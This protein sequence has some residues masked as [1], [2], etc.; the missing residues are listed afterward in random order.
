MS[1]P[2]TQRLVKYMLT[3]EISP[4]AEQQQKRFAEFMKL[5]QKEVDQ[6]IQNSADVRVEAE[7]SSADRITEMQRE[8]LTVLEDIQK[9]STTLV[10]M[11]QAEQTRIVEEANRA[12]EEAEKDSLR[13]IDEE[14]EKHVETVKRSS[15]ELTDGYLAAT[16]GFITLAQGAA[17]VGILAEEDAEKMLRFIVAIRGVADVAKGG[18]ELYRGISAAV[19]AYRAS[20]VAATAAE[21]ALAAA[22]SRTGAA[23]NLGLAG[24]A[25]SGA[26]SGAGGLTTAVSGLSLSVAALPAAIAAAIVGTVGA[27]AMITNIGGSR[28]YV[29]GMLP[30]GFGTPG[31][32]WFDW[33]VGNPTDFMSGFM[34]SGMDQSGMEDWINERRN[35]LESQQT[36][37]S[38]IASRQDRLSMQARHNAAA[39]SQFDL[40]LQMDQM[41]RQRELTVDDLFGGPTADTILSRL[42]LAQGRLGNANRVR[43]EADAMPADALTRQG[44]IARANEMQIRALEEVIALRKQAVM[45]QQQE[46]QQALALAKEETQEIE[47]QLELKKSEQQRIESQL[48]SARQRFG[49]LDE[50]TQQQAIAAF[51]KAQAGGTLN[52]EE[53]SLLRNVGTQQA[54]E[55]AQAADLARADSANF[56]QIFGAAE[57]ATVQQLLRDANKLKL[58]LKDKREVEVELKDDLERM[59]KLAN[60]MAEE[61]AS[62][63]NERDERLLQRFIAILEQ[64]LNNDNGNFGGGLRTGSS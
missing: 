20:V 27:G 60:R 17:S 54:T 21:T 4:D 7:K 14:Y 48:L 3:V 8:Q 25:A 58:E 32:S 62:Q 36:T 24:T 53:S 33:A 10:E 47:R 22:R 59:E 23:G 9:Q 64:K 50:A 30:E 45:L 38:R 63:I 51:R 37:D 61:T 35:A 5:T 16:E 11:Q 42:S 6:A 56:T 15:K 2:S 49:Q 41:R 31:N 12:R 44:D 46:G 19:E 18:V 26:V 34:P 29:A 28:D 55:F 52:R 39:Q 1:D 40:Q 57:N 13:R 43:A